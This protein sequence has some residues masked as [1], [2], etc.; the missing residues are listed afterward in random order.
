MRTGGSSEEATVTDQL[1]KSMMARFQEI[2]D[3]AKQYQALSVLLTEADFAI[4]QACTPH[5]MHRPGNAGPLVIVDGSVFRQK[6]TQPR[7]HRCRLDLT[8]ETPVFDSDGGE[9]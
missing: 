5:T 1:T 6:S 8:G 2:L 9:R 4:M 3:A 7:A